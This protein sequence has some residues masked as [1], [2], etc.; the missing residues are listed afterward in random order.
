MH[1]FLSFAHWVHHF[2]AVFSKVHEFLQNSGFIPTSARFVIFAL[3]A[4]LFCD[5]QQSTQVCAK[6]CFSPEINTF[7]HLRT[8]R[9]TF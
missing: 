7:C 5:F 1:H 2:L 8:G 6:Q 4:P 3:G 9:I